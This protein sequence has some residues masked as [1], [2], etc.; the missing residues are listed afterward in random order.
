M[1]CDSVCTCM[2]VHVAYM[3]VKYPYFSRTVTNLGTLSHCPKQSLHYPDYFF[4]PRSSGGGAAQLMH[5]REMEQST[6]CALLSCKLNNSSSFY[7]FE[8]PTELLKMDKT[9]TVNYNKAHCS[10]LTVRAVTQRAAR[11]AKTTYFRHSGS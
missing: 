11:S 9:A 2:N 5:T 7:D 6:L 8:T 3:H 4:A 1:Q 10:K